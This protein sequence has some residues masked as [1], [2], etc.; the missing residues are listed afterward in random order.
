MP[1]QA[2]YDRLENTN[3]V[4]QRLKA[5]LNNPRS[6]SISEVSVV[7]KLFRRARM[8]RGST[9]D[10]GFVSLAFIICASVNNCIAIPVLLNIFPR[11]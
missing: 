1:T 6:P 8:T 3:Q 10:P 11:K 2:N 9:E 5:Q 4:M 7:Q